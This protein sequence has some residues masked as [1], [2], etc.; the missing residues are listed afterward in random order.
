MENFLI[1]EL[2]FIFVNY[3]Y[4]YMIGFAGVIGQILIKNYSVIFEF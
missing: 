4:N 1:N 2:P 3:N